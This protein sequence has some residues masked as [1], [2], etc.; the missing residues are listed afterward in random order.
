[1]ELLGAAEDVIELPGAIEPVA[2]EGVGFGLDAECPGTHPEPGVV[3]AGVGH[4]WKPVIVIVSS[5]AAMP[6]DVRADE[7][8]RT[9]VTRLEI[10][11]AACDPQEAV[12][13]G[14]RSVRHGEIRR[15]G[16]TERLTVREDGQA[17]SVITRFGWGETNA[18]LGTANGRQPLCSALQRPLVSLKP[19][20]G[21]DQRL[22]GWRSEGRVEAD[23]IRIEW[24]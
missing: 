16:G 13:R 8:K 19:E 24:V 20:G 15:D 11:P 6:T 9:A 17:Q 22:A 1:M 18:P 5:A 10:L 4:R 7:R 12:L 2:R 14:R 23:D 21:N 3:F